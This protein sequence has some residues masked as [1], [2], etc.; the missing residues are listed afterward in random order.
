MPFKSYLINKILDRKFRVNGIVPSTR[1]PHKHHLRQS[2]DQHRIYS[3]D[4]L[5]PKVDLRPEM[6]PVEDQSQIGSW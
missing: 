2:F 3:D 6:P 4:Q 5:P 1:L